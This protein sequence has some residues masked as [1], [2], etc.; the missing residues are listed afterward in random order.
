MENLTIKGIVK[1]YVNMYFNA[2]NQTSKLSVLNDIDFTLST[3]VKLAIYKEII[4]KLDEQLK[5]L[6]HENNDNF[7]Q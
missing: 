2:P 3:S 7:N 1:E 4:L 5:I 6:N